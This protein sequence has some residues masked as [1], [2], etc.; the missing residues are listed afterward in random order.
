MRYGVAIFKTIDEHINKPTLLFFSCRL[1]CLGTCPYLRLIYIW[2]WILFD[3]TSSPGIWN[4]L[5][6]EMRSGLYNLNYHFIGR[7]F[8]LIQTKCYHGNP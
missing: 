1:C 6:L 3:I 7:N 2:S 5:L 4:P 8:P